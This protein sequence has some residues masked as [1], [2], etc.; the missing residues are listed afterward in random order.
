MI[1][2]PK[3]V[4]AAAVVFLAMPGKS[5][6]EEI[7]QAS[8]TANCAVCHGATGTGNGPIVDLLK[9]APPDLAGL[10]KRNGGRFPFKSVYETITDAGKT[11][12]HGTNEMPI[13]GTR[14]NAEII[15][16]EGEFGT[17]ESGILPA[18]ARVLELVFFLAT[19]QEP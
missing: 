2:H 10:A 3:T 19:I 1:S 5:V 14:F 12:G 6:A 11:R 18:Q 7:G 13:W 16:Q 15:R 8:F 4:L 17:G 9:T